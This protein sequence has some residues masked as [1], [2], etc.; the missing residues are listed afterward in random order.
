MKRHSFLIKIS[1]A[2]IGVAILLATFEFE[3]RDEVDSPV[4]ESPPRNVVSFRDAD[5][6]L[7][8]AFENRQS[9]LQVMGHGTVTKK[10]P[11]DNQ[12][13]R[14]QR[15]I[16]KLDSGQT[17]LVAHNIDVA[18]RIDSLKV[19]DRIDFYGEYE[20]NAEGGVL[21]WTHHATSGNHPDGWLKHDG[22][23][24]E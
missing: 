16:L 24:Y 10:L 12:G 9:D 15:F 14:H 6:V 5:D 8:K 13:S 4:S 7:A 23:I 21:H 1:Y 11:D 2:L 17:I 19:G 3:E 18:A 22:Q 20:W